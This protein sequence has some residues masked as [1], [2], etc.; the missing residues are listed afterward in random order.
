LNLSPFPGLVCLRQATQAIHTAFEH[1]LK[2]A[3]PDAQR[4]DYCNFIEAMWGWLS[5]FEQALWE[6]KWPSEMQADLRNNKREWLREDLRAAG[7]DDAAISALPLAPCELDL[8][9]PASRFG[10][11]YVLEGS[12]LGSQVLAKRLGPILAP[13]PARWLHGYGRDVSVRWRG[14]LASLENHVC[15]DV[16]IAQASHAA[17]ETF[18]SLQRWFQLRGAA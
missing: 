3:K 16:A 9:T 15:D 12:Q 8:Q 7:L 2:I 5:P 4:Q 11:A 14:F 13:W 10:V 18:V 17:Q 1:Q 6:A